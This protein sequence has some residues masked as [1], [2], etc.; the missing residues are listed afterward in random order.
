MR[1]KM[2]PHHGVP[3]FETSRQVAVVYRGQ[4]WRRQL[5]SLLCIHQMSKLLMHII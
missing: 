1:Q 4:D 3:N 2:A 5:F